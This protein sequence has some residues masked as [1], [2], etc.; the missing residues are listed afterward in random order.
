VNVSEYIAE[1]F[2]KK[3]IKDIFLIDG[4]ACASM[5]VGVAKNKNLNY[6]CPHHEQAGAFAIDGY[7]KAS[8]SPSVMIA[9]SGPAGQNLI[10][11]IAA[12]WYDS[13]PAIYLTGNINS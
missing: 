6:Y 4:A 3:G 7:V 13:V 5:I 1:F 2:V 10:N 9:T 12:S 11:G 8:G